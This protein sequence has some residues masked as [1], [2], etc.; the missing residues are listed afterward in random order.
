[1]P[2]LIS[3]VLAIKVLKF[4]PRYSGDEIKDEPLPMNRREGKSGGKFTVK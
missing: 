3:D 4:A 2:R 1:M